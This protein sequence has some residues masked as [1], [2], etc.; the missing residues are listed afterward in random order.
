MPQRLNVAKLRQIAAANDDT[1]DADICRRADIG[2]ATLSRLV[3]RQAQPMFSTVSKL[4]AAYGLK[5]DD[6][7][8]SSELLAE[9]S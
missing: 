4:A 9:A 3:N 1:S 5:V 2:K 8:E 7:V 6:L